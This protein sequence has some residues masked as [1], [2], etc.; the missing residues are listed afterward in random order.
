MKNCPRCGA[1]VQDRAAYCEYC[2]APVAQTESSSTRPSSEKKTP[3][4]AERHTFPPL[5]AFGDPALPKARLKRVS[6]FLMILFTLFT[7]FIYPAVWVFHRRE[8]F[9][10]MSPSEK[11]GAFLPKAFLAAA[12]GLAVFGNGGKFLPIPLAAE[13]MEMIT[14]WF[15]LAWIVLSTLLTFRI[16]RILRDY[17]SRMDKS[18]LAANLVARSGLFAFLFQFLYIQHNINLLIETGLAERS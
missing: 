9:D 6:P 12:I 13:E 11:I 18:P 10:E 15:F 17:A 8:V 2:G 5:N 1:V 14:G 3:P 16:R 4:A 7:F